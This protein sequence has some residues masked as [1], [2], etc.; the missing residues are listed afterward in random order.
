MA[1][2]VGRHALGKTIAF[3]SFV[4]KISVYPIMQCSKGGSMQH[5]LEKA[6]R[7]FQDQGRCLAQKIERAWRW[8][9]YTP[10]V[11]LTARHKAD[12]VKHL[13][14]LRG[15]D[16]FL[17]FGH[18]AT[19]AQIERY[20]EG[21]RWEQDQVYGI[22]DYKERLLAMAHLAELGPLQGEPAAEFGVSV[23]KGAR[24]KGLGARLFAHAVDHA[25]NH[26]IA[27]LCIHALNENKPMLSIARHAGARF[28][29]HG[30]ETEGFLHVEKGPVLGRFTEGL[31][32]LF[33]RTEYEVI[34]EVHHVQQWLALV[35]EVRNGVRQGRHRSAS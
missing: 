14:A 9:H 10:I 6:M 29:R 23:R 8:L 28:E 32:H 19:D 22:Y 4:Q 33:A 34:H 18:A 7:K 1:S 20:V 31:M 24:G 35:D 16:R 3:V 27:W 13:Q 30:T 25:R 11:H 12:V 15:H 21:I 17:R 2:R 26:G 5:T